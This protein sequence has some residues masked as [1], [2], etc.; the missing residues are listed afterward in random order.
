[1]EKRQTSRA[2]RIVTDIGHSRPSVTDPEPCPLGTRWAAWKIY[3]FARGASG[4]THL[5]PV[6]REA[7]RRAKRRR[8]TWKPVSPLAVEW[9]VGPGDATRLADGDGLLHRRRHLHASTTIGTRSIHI[10]WATGMGGGPGFSYTLV[11]IYVDGALVDESAHGGSSLGFTL[12]GGPA[13]AF[14]R[15]GL[16]VGVA[17]DWFRSA[18]PPTVWLMTPDRGE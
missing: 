13:L 9:S 15:R 8:L 3:V 6:E 4:G 7:V 12:W 10:D 11:H 17:S 2:V 1:L 5:T 14:I 16:A 18:S